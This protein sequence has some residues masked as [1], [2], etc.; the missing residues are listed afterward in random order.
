MLVIQFG[1]SQIARGPPPQI[2]NPPTR[3]IWIR[4][5]R[6]HR[7]GHSSCTLCPRLK[8]APTVVGLL[9]LLCHPPP[10]TFFC[11]LQGRLADRHGVPRLAADSC[12]MTQCSMT[13][14]SITHHASSARVCPF[15]AGVARE[16]ALST[17]DIR[18]ETDN[19]KSM[20]SGGPISDTR[21]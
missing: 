7:G 5:R 14:H 16:Q 1:S 18:T 17:L 13:H 2:R 20:Y 3:Q 8:S 11:L 9:G 6:D 19:Y 21:C 4:E 12:P 10:L 15:R